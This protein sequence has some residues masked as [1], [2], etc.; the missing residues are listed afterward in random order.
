VYDRLGAS[1]TA[2]AA[3]TADKK[4]GEGGDGA[5]DGVPARRQKEIA[6]EAADVLYHLLVLLQARGSPLADVAAVCATAKA[7]RRP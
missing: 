2:A 5:G 1:V 4:I 3:R 7:K 6:A